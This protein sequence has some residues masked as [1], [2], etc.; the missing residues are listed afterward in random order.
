[1]KALN[2]ILS[3]VFPGWITLSEFSETYLRIV[4]G[5]PLCEHTKVS[6]RISIAHLLRGLGDM[7][8][9]SIKPV[10]VQQA[11]TRI[12]D[13][14][15]PCAAKRFL[16]HAK[17]LFA[18]A[19]YAGIITSNPA[20]HVRR[21][22]YHVARSR[23]SFEVW[24]GMLDT[25][26]KSS[27]RW[28]APM[29]LLALVTA[30]RRGDLVKMR[31]SDVWDDCLHIEQQKTSA[32]IALPLALRL[33]VIGLSVGDVIER[34]RGYA[35]GN[36]FMLRTAGGKN[37]VSNCLSTRFREVLVISLGGRWN[38]PGTPPTLHECRSLSE[39]LYREQGIDTQTL[40]G[41]KTQR[42]TDIYNDDRGLNKDKWRVLRLDYS[43]SF[44][45]QSL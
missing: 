4:W 15:S 33:D 12:I 34:C 27:V 3:R 2:R 5:R 35:R 32:R 14:G 29:L 21:P 28:I 24:R 36:K 8:M 1:M 6:Y 25:A 40:L 20:E 37:V 26:E 30:Q 43:P 13:N 41:H 22:S 45:A 39:R 23:L 44:S 42:M 19:I 31:F 18:E 10:H 11:M 16:C 9:R 17:D 38:R 7:Q